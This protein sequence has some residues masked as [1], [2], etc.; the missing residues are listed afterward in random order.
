MCMKR[1]IIGMLWGTMTLLV[2]SQSRIDLYAPL[3]IP[4]FLSANFGELRPNHFHNGLDMKTQ[5]RVGLPVYAVDEGYVSRILVMHGGYGQAVFITHPNGLTSVYGHVMDFSKEIKQYVRKYQYLHETFVCDL[6]LHS[7]ELPVKRGE[8][9][10]L[11]GNEGSSMG[12]HLHFELRRTATNIYLDP[13]PFFTKEID[14]TRPPVASL[15][16]LYPVKDKGMVDGQQ[17]R[18]LLPVNSITRGFTAWGDVYAG[19]SAHDVMNGTSNIYGI[20]KLELYVDSVR[21]FSHIIDEVSADENRMINAYTDYAELVRSRRLIM[22]SYLLSQNTLN[23]LKANPDRGIVRID[24]ERDYH[25]RYV[26]T[27]HFGNSRSYNFIVRGVRQPIADAKING[28]EVLKADRTNIISRPGFEM[29][30]PAGYVYEDTP[31]S[32]EVESDST[33]LSF[34][35]RISGSEIPLHNYC[36]LQI[37]LRNKPIEDVSKYYI[38]RGEGRYRSYVGGSFEKGWLRAQVRELGS[39]R[40]AIDTIAPDIVPIGQKLWRRTRNVRFRINDNAT[41]ISSYKVF[42]DGRFVLF[43]LK[44]GM[45]IVQDPDRLPRSGIHVIKVVVADHCGNVKEKTFNF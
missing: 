18:S 41:G 38:E 45:L 11:S 20:Y 27:D 24:E 17:K 43:G 31:Y 2:N 25:F 36:T 44:R 4:I 7:G 9:I 15:I 32:V 29:V 5:G 16:A 26:L 22:R 12:P 37:G 39:Y 21:M 28:R 1:Y 14:D 13:M 19:I 6:R 34:V 30:I 42:V 40:I 23:F 3:D 10:A 33:Q 8:F 35:Y